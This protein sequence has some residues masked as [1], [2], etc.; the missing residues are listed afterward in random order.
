MEGFSMTH[1]EEERIRNQDILM[2]NLSQ[3]ISV[4]LNKF[5]GIVDNIILV[6]DNNSWRKKI[7]IPDFLDSVTYKGNRNFDKEI[8]FGLIFGTLNKLIENAKH[9][10]ITIS[11]YDDIEGDDWAW[12][13]S[14]KLL[15]DGINSI[16]WTT[17][18]DIK[19]LIKY[20]NGHWIAWYNSKELFFHSDMDKKIDD[21]DFFMNIKEDFGPLYKSI[22][23]SKRFRV[24]YKN[25]DIIVME[26]I[27]CGDSGDNI[28]PIFTRKSTSGRSM[29]YTEKDL[30][31]VLNK[32]NITK[33]SDFFNNFD[34]IYKDVENNGKFKN[35]NKEN[36]KQHFAY[37]T[38][39]VWLNESQ[40]PS[41]LQEKM[42][43]SN[44]KEYDIS[45]IKNN[46]KILSKPSDEEMENLF[47]T[48]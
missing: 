43:L 29:R 25:P 2:N 28:F 5:N 15:S 39:L 38:K 48:L 14:N 16:I 9:E 36:C 13:W 24:L 32:H 7:K 11:K 19:Q 41:I 23:I 34:I 4:V 21:L 17:D 31:K 6:G 46:Y 12:Y 10:G 42:I 44:Y 45:N 20:D 8:D 47:N 27:I 3:S 37:N 18:N 26:K 1:S 40:I 33:L 22:V 30:H 35:L